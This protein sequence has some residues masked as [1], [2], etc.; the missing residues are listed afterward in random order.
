MATGR[1]PTHSR[2]KPGQSGNPGGRPKGSVNLGSLLA[3]ALNE[4]VTVTEGGRRRTI[5]K[6][7]VSIKQLVNKAAGGDLRSMRLVL[8]MDKA[9]GAGSRHMTAS[10]AA[11]ALAGPQHPRID[12]SKKT[13]RE[14]GVLYEAALIIEGKQERPPPPMPPGDPEEADE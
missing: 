14:L 5:S 4:K 3:K 12:L 8:E 2:F 7:E 13:K 6:G 11:D 9:H 1:P 10:V